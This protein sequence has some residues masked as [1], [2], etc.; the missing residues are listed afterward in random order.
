MI[1]RGTDNTMIKRGTDNT[2]IKQGTDN[3]MIKR[4]RTKEQTTIYKT[5]LIKRKIE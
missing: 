2:M 4:N 3:T 1:K 5:L